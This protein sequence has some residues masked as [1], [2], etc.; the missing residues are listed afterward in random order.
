MITVYPKPTAAF[1]LPDS[2]GMIAPFTDLS[3]FNI[4]SWSWNFGD[5]NTSNQT[6]PTHTYQTNGTYQVQL[7][8]Q[9]T[10]G[11]LDTLVQE[12]RNYQIPVA[13][14]IPNNNCLT[15]P[16]LLS[17]NSTGQIASWNWTT[18]NTSQTTQNFNYTFNS[19]GTYP[20]QLIIQ[21]VDGCID[22]AYNQFEVYPLPFISF[23]SPSECAGDSVTF[24]NLSNGAVA[25]EWYLNG[26]L[27]STN[28]NPKQV[29]PWG[30]YQIHLI[31]TNQYGCQDSLLQTL[32]V[33]PRPI[34]NFG[35]QFEGCIPLQVFLDNQT[36]IA[37]GGLINSYIWNIGLNT[38]YTEDINLT[39]TTAGN[40]S[41]TLT[42]ISD[43]GCDSTIT[44][45]D[46]IKT[47]PLPVAGFAYSPENPNTANTKIEFTNLSQ[48]NLYNTWEI[49][50]QTFT[51]THL[52]YTFPADTGR[53]VIYLHVENEFGC[54]DSIYQ[55]LYINSNFTVYIPNTFTP[56]RDGL[57]DTFKIYGTG[58]VEAEMLIFDRWGELL[59]SYKNL[60][61]MTKGWDGKY[62]RTS[63]K[64]DV[65]I[66]KI[67]VRDFTG[68]WHDFIGQINLLK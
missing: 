26:N 49:Q 10:D 28:I 64:Q 12:Y 33:Y 30:Q 37:P 29:Y 31:G 24:T 48:G 58:I 43:K 54:T 67:K 8:V 45:I 41:V 32:E 65:Y 56:T 21:S 52:S 59:S 4:A 38:Y 66:Y 5:G 36:T 47:Y 17:D 9:N 40:Y 55:Y 18:N 25:Y 34:P 27:F 6:S 39:Y 51:E 16:T 22:T 2:C 14:I 1:V 3:L 61:P 20:V 50:F 68:E 15:Y 7:I 42:A 57:N 19:P 23:I 11:C 62:N 63:V 35:G 53:Y 44:F 46:V 13:S 60:E